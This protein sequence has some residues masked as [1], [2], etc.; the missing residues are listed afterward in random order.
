VPAKVAAKPPADPDTI[1]AATVALIQ[2]NEA[3]ASARVAE[4]VA[5]RK[6]GEAQTRFAAAV[7]AFQSGFVP[8]TKEN[9][10]R[11]FIASEIESRRRAAAGEIA[12]QE[13]RVGNSVIDRQRAW[14]RSGGPDSGR[15]NSGRAV[16]EGGKVY[17]QSMRGVLIPKAPSAR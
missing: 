11:E 12:P 17:P 7:V 15:G 2:A 9:L 4:N 5:G 10:A 8:V 13:Y 1:E 6:Q 14:A 3:L 16:V